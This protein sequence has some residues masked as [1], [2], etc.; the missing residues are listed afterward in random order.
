MQ[1]SALNFLVVD[2]CDLTRALHSAVLRT[3]GHTVEEADDGRNALRKLLRHKFDCIITDNQMPRLGGVALVK[4]VNHFF[5]PG[6]LPIFIVSADDPVSIRKALG[7]LGQIEVFQKPMSK[8]KFE[9]I[10]DMIYRFRH[11]F[12]K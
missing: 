6:C 5:G 4:R 10:I 12:S 9:D 11:E 8:R 7:V 3:L 2:D 1:R